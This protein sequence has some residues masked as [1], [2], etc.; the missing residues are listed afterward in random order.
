MG[1]DTY[2]SP[3]VKGP[4]ALGGLGLFSTDTHSLHCLYVD[5]RAFERIDRGTL[6]L[7]PQRMPLEPVIVRTVVQI[8]LRLIEFRRTHHLI[9][10]NILRRWCHNEAVPVVVCILMITAYVIFD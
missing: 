6:R 5:Q 2:L 8:A 4:D 1:G 10:S 3:R 9:G 7:V